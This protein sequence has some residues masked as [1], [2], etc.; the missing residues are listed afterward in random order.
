[1]SWLQSDEVST[2]DHS[3]ELIL[4]VRDQRVS[5]KQ[6]QQCSP[7]TLFQTIEAWRQ[8]SKQAV[9]THEMLVNTLLGTA[10]YSVKK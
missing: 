5:G 7:D 1:V 8:S 2:P 3:E 10:G 9:I 4:A 6:L